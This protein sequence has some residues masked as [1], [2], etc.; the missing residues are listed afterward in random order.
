MMKQKLSL[1]IL[2]LWIAPLALAGGFEKTTSL[3]ARA[4]AM[5]G[6]GAAYNNTVSAAFYNP[7]LFKYVNTWTMGVD[8]LPT[9]T[10]SNAFFPSSNS[11][12]AQLNSN[13]GF[14]PIFNIAGV[15]RLSDRMVAGLAVNTPA[16]LKS[17]TEIPGTAA[18]AE[19]DFRV[20]EVAPFVVVDLGQGLSVSAQYRAAY[21]TYDSAVTK[22][23]TIKDMTGTN[24]SGARVGLAYELAQNWHWGLSVRNATTTTLS[25]KVDVGNV[26]NAPLKLQ[27]VTYPWSFLSGVAYVANDEAFTVALDT[28]YTL[29]NQVTSLDY[30]LNNLDVAT[31]WNNTFKVMVGGEFKVARNWFARVGTGLHTAVTNAAF[32]SQL[33]TPPGMGY[34]VGTGMGYRLDQW[35]VDLS[36][37]VDLGRGTGTVRNASAP[38]DHTAAAYSVGLSLNY[39]AI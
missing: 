5:G 32:D 3:G 21:A 37:G 39:T 7:A 28:Q 26:V 4:A 27:D 9:V 33:F 18:V 29:Y 11:P 13:A 16:G 24:F 1:G 30:D 36:Y 38:T 25:G 8:F 15:G 6:V 17:R 31:N 35:A 19:V 20:L 12:G 22:A 14:L 34:S 2:G 23:F 10:T